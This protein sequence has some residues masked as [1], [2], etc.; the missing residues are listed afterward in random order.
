MAAMTKMIVTR[1]TRDNVEFDEGCYSSRLGRSC[2][3]LRAL[4]L[5]ELSVRLRHD[6]DHSWAEADVYCVRRRY[7]PDALATQEFRR[8]R[9]A[10]RPHR[11]CPVTINLH[12]PSTVGSECASMPTAACVACLNIGGTA[13]PRRTEPAGDRSSR[14]AMR[15]ASDFSGDGMRIRPVDQRAFAT[16]LGCAARQKTAS[17]ASR[18]T[19]KCYR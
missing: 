19:W 6:V 10:R 12:G 2:G 7:G 9:S 14:C 11:P 8:P 4:H 5:R 15:S 17:A 3:R 16:A 18:P 1:A 13:H